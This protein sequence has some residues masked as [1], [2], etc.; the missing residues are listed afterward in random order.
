MTWFKVDDGFWSHPKVLDCPPRALALWV[1]AGSWCG[2]HLSDG[3][4]PRSALLMFAATP[5]DAAALVERGLWS[6]TPDGWAFHDWLDHQ[7]TRESV[8]KRRSDDTERKRLAREQRDAQRLS[9]RNPHGHSAESA[10]NPHGILAPS[11]DGVRTESALPDP[12]RPDPTRKNNPPGGRR[13]SAPTLLAVDAIPEPESS[14]AQAIIGRWITACGDKRPPSSVIG[15]VGKHVKA[16]LAEGIDPDD[17]EN[18]MVVWHRKRLGPSLLPS[19]VH[20]VRQ[21]PAE[22]KQSSE[23]ATLSAIFNGTG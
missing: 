13:A 1:R 8:K 4:V 7:P 19:V 5:A 22:R 11:D 18:G 6:T 16:M 12:T 21:G 9:A 10:R 23:A 20:E 2:Q 15:Q 3:R 14:A 17:V